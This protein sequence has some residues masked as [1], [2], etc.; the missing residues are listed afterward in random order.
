MAEATEKKAGRQKLVVGVVTSNRMNKTIVVLSAPVAG[1]TG[2]GRDTNTNRVTASGLSAMSLAS[3]M[4]PW[5]SPATCAQIA[6]SNRE[7]G[8]ATSAA[9]AAVEPPSVIIAW[10][11]LAAS[12]SRHCAAAWG[13]VSTRLTPGS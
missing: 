12:Q 1:P 13:W 4:S 5:S 9:A 2:P 11:R 10:A 6:A 3:G 7:A 8:S